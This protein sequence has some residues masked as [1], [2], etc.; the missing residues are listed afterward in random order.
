MIKKF[1]KKETIGTK[2]CV[3][4]LIIAAL[5]GITSKITTNDRKNNPINIIVTT[6]SDDVVEYV[7]NS[8]LDGYNTFTIDQCV[9][10]YL[11]NTEWGAYID[12]NGNK[13]ITVIGDVQSIDE[14]S[15]QCMHFYI[16][17]DSIEVEFTS[18]CYEDGTRY[19]EGYDGDYYPHIEKI[20][21]GGYM[22]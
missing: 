20:F 6:S 13:Y 14:E 12:N 5:M 4:I 1:W 7:K 21:N 22:F 16:K 10:S 19:A 2:V 18:L 8:Y 15:R 9:T 17:Q 11:H 3:V